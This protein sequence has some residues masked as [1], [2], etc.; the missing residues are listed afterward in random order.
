MT[1]PYQST[2]RD[3]LTKAQEEL[4]HGDLLQASE[5]GWG[6]AAQTVKAAAAARG[7]SHRSHGQLFDGARR[8]AEEAGDDRIRELFSA[9]SALHQNF[10]ENWWTQDSVAGGLRD[11]EELMRRVAP[12]IA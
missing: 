2:A 5:K 9:A 11:V 6:A 4:S 1:A 8:L 10:Y 3:F 7:W 12:L